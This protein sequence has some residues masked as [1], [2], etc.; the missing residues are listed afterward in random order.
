MD[1]KVSEK[2]M[3]EV[4]FQAFGKE[5]DSADRK[6]APLPLEI[7]YLTALNKLKREGKYAGGGE[8]TDDAYYQSVNHFVYFC[9][10]YQNDFL[11]AFGSLKTHLSNKFKDYYNKYGTYGVMIHFYTELDSENRRILTDYSLKNYK[12]TPISSDIS[13]I[14][15]FNSV[16]HFIYFCFNF[17]SNFM[18]AFSSH[19]KVHL[20]SKWTNAY[21]K[22]GSVVVMIYF[23]SEL[24]NENRKKLATWSKNNYTG[25]KLYEVGGALGDVAGMLPS[26]LPMS[27]IQAMADGGQLELFADGGGVGKKSDRNETQ[28]NN[29]GVS[30]KL[31]DKFIL[32]KKFGNNKDVEVSITEIMPSGLFFK[33]DKSDKTFSIK[34]L[35][36][37]GSTYT[38]GEYLVP[39]KNQYSDG[40]G[41]GEFPPKGELTNKDNFLLKYEK[42]GSDYEFFV[43][44][45]ITKEVSGYNQIKHVC[46]NKDCPQKM[47]YEQFIN[48]LYV[49]LYLDDNKYADGGLTRGE[50]ENK[51]EGLRLRIAKTKKQI[52]GYETTERGKYN[53]LFQEK[54]VPLQKE[55][56]TLSDLYGK[57]KYEKGGGVGDEVPLWTIR[58]YNDSLVASYLDEKKLIAWA[59]QLAKENSENIEINSVQQA[60]TYIEKRDKN[61]EQ[62]F[63]VYENYADGGGVDV[64]KSKTLIQSMTAKIFD[65]KYA[66]TGEDWDS[67]M[68]KKYW[69]YSEEEAVNKLKKENKLPKDFKYSN[70]GGVESDYFI[71]VNNRM[72]DPYQSYYRVESSDIFNG[73]Q[74]YYDVDG[75]AYTIDEDNYSDFKSG[76]NAIFGDTLDTVI[77]VDFYKNDEDANNDYYDD[78]YFIN[79]THKHVTL[80]PNFNKYYGEWHKDKSDAEKELKSLENKFSDG[81]GVDVV[82]KFTYNKE[83]FE[84]KYPNGDEWSN[85][86]M[87][88]FE[89]GVTG[90]T[91][92]ALR[93]TKHFPPARK[94][95]F[96]VSIYNASELSKS[97]LKKIKGLNE[98]FNDYKRGYSYSNGGGV[99]DDSKFINF[100]KQLIKYSDFNEK[101]GDGFSSRY[102]GLKNKKG[103]KSNG[104]YLIEGNTITWVYIDEKGNEYISDE[105]P[106]FII[107][108]TGKKESFN[109]GYADGGGVNL[110][111]PLTSENEEKYKKLKENIIKALF[112]DKEFIVTEVTFKYQ[113]KYSVPNTTKQEIIGVVFEINQSKQYP[114][115]NFF[116]NRNGVLC[117]DVLQS[118]KME[119]GGVVDAEG[120][121]IKKGYKVTNGRGLVGIVKEVQ[122]NG[123]LYI[124]WISDN[125]EETRDLM[126]D[127]DP[128]ELYVIL[129]Y[130]K[131]GEIQKNNFY[132]KSNFGHWSVIDKKNNKMVV[133]YS[134]KEDAIITSKGLNDIDNLDELNETIIK[135]K[136]MKGYGYFLDKAFADGGGVEPYDEEKYSSE[137]DY[138]KKIITKN[139]GEKNTNYS[140]AD[141]GGIDNWTIKG[142]MYEGVFIIIDD[143]RDVILME[144]K[145]NEEL[146]ENEDTDILYAEVNDKSALQKL[147]NMAL[148]IKYPLNKYDDGGGVDVS[149]SGS[150][151]DNDHITYEI[152]VNEINQNF[153]H[154]LIGTIEKYDEN[155]YYAT[156]INELYDDIEQEEETFSNFSDAEKWVLGKLND[157]KEYYVENYSGY[158]NRGETEFPIYT[159]GEIDGKPFEVIGVNYKKGFVRVKNFS[160]KGIKEMTISEWIPLTFELGTPA[161]FIMNGREVSGEV[162]MRNGEKAISLYRDDNYGGDSERISFFNQIDLKTLRPFIE[163]ET[164]SLGGVLE[165]YSDGGDLDDSKFRE[166]VKVETTVF[167]STEDIGGDED[168]EAGTIGIVLSEPSDE[169]DLVLV[170]IK[171]NRHYLPQNVLEVV[172][173]YNND[174]CINFILDM[175]NKVKPILDY[176]ISDKKLIIVLKEQLT[177]D[178]IEFFNNN[179]KNIKGCSEVTDDEFTISYKENNKT[180]ILNLKT[181]DFSIQKFKNGGAVGELPLA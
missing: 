160:E 46:L 21:E 8:I 30:Y 38:S 159:Y 51:I 44:K 70:G 177:I 116:T 88:N 83:D 47:T 170:E 115:I 68:F 127:N 162:V 181:D 166:G 171:G 107:D 101:T 112:I 168:I 173:E 118:D 65:D 7:A 34:T 144:R 167:M 114:P 113:G 77:S 96:S 154:K 91:W 50:I 9:M 86:G 163:K 80:I 155:E 4:Y 143:N 10:N 17:P 122:T 158:S 39:I 130:D 141:W 133:G 3:R 16:N 18:D 57:S 23:W 145:H 22:K 27:T 73:K 179:L 25:T 11:D 20:S 72:F 148:Q 150:L 40:G 135:L 104:E 109:K 84:I 147:F 53:K 82:L 98:E 49:E 136:T 142:G 54:V 12:G 62:Y 172:S 151:E 149:K 102:V 110:F 66:G 61:D 36:S 5:Y 132:V 176:G 180:L 178:E 117:L 103:D 6:Q 106:E 76:D 81:G 32:G 52:S 24:D 99:D 55:L 124:Q 175:V 29:F 60:I 71:A 128:K 108:L 119:N 63:E 85:N 137:Y 42:K 1:S 13:D 45:P 37:K 146:E 74:V 169:E 15:Y 2:D 67:K 35:H 100:K 111:Q 90:G 121:I 92:M 153:Y 31:G 97:E 123:L 152:S 125:G 28:E 138:L 93:I 19:L 174:D 69:S 161:S 157:E 94:N 43:Y 89:T 105:V 140:S 56:D 26:P 120:E 165:T 75:E 134:E 156:Y 79:N 164:F 41:V 48:Y 58:D 64:D 129:G 59:F 78:E 33:V 126:A 14:E 95:S 131:G 139:F 87:V